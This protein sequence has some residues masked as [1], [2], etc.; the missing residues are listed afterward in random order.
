MG[1]SR[2]WAVLALGGAAALAGCK[3]P[4]PL[5]PSYDGGDSLAYI[6]EEPADREP[7]EDRSSAEEP[8]LPVMAA[9][10]DVE[11]MLSERYH[12]VRKGDTLM[13]LARHYYQDASRWRVILESNRDQIS[14]PN[15]V[16]V[17]QRLRIP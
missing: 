11:P 17:G 5:D 10:T 9:P 8:I 15:V 3:A 12:V 6:P 14:N 7:M 4:D 2:A 1:G 16:R 13:A